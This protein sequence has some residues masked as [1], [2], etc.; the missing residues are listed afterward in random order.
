MPKSQ[1]DSHAANIRYTL[2]LYRKTQN[3]LRRARVITDVYRA[4]HA[5]AV[6]HRHN[7]GQRLDTVCSFWTQPGC[8]NSD[9]GIGLAD[10]RIFG[11]RV[12]Q[13]TND[14]RT[15]ER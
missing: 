8:L 15:E 3:F 13:R 2:L 6:I 14:K 7:A 9:V 12:P 10:G 11:D 4:D 5:G 1:K